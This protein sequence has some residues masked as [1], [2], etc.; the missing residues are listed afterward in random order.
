LLLPLQLAFAFV[1]GATDFGEFKRTEFATGCEYLGVSMLDTLQQALPRLRNLYNDEASFEQIYKFA[2]PYMCEKG[3]RIMDLEQALALWRQL[4][5]GKH[6]W[7]HTELWCT[8]LQE[9][10]KRPI[11]ADTWKLLLPFAKVCLWLPLDWCPAGCCCV[12]ER[13]ADSG[14]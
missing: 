9:C 11:V 2:F 7:K 5:A 12:R 8:F 13:Q 1:C 3:K 10:H 14:P 4:F 6:K